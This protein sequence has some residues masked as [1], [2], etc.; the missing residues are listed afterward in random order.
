MLFRSWGDLLG[1]FESLHD[2][3]D[4][5]HAALHEQVIC[6]PKHFF[7]IN[8]GHRRRGRVSRFRSHARFSFGPNMETLERALERLGR[9][10][11]GAK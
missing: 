8:P 6:V 11:R 2:S 9:V 4:F 7:D 1:L 10:V 3:D 5:F